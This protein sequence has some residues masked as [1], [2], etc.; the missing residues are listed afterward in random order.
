[1]DGLSSPIRD[2]ITLVPQ[3]DL[4]KDE[5]LDVIY[6]NEEFKREQW[7]TFEVGKTRFNDQAMKKASECDV[8]H[9]FATE[10]AWH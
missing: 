9:W 10:V 1:M 2:I 7:T 5:S 3:T 6:I 4:L 8:S